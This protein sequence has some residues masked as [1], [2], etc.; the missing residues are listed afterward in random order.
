[1]STLKLRRDIESLRKVLGRDEKSFERSATTDAEVG[2]KL[3][4]VEDTLVDGIT[5]LGSVD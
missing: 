1:M 4:D 2:E 5:R 3:V